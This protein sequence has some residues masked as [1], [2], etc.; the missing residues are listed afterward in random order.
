MTELER[1][2]EEIL[3]ARRQTSEEAKAGGEMERRDR[4][5][6]ESY[7]REFERRYSGIGAIAE[8]EKQ[9]VAWANSQRI[10]DA[11]GKI[12]KGRDFYQHLLQKAREEFFR[13]RDEG[14][15]PEAAFDRCTSNLT[16][17]IEKSETEEK[18]GT[19]YLNFS[20]GFLHRLRHMED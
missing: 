5:R 12:R 11:N 2:I 3:S 10:E 18:G 15:E 9:L 17:W 4:K 13:L 20:P 16:D 1:A 6:R 8:M 14:Y 19:I 7:L